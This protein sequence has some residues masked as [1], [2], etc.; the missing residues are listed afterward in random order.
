MKND[1]FS[2]DEIEKKYKQIIDHYKNF[3]PYN[4]YQQ[5][6]NYILVL[7]DWKDKFK[8][9]YASYGFEKD[10]KSLKEHISSLKKKKV[11]KDKEKEEIELTNIEKELSELTKEQYD[12]YAFYFRLLENIFDHVEKGLYYD[13]TFQFEEIQNTNLKLLVGYEKKLI[14]LREKLND[15]I[16]IIQ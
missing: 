1:I 11:F 6:F 8:E 13:E 9:I 14:I 2:K 15:I 12:N 10:I 16:K 3:H 5:Q 4:Y 7:I